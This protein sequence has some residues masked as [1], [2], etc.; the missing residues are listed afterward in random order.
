MKIR[1]ILKVAA[2]ALFAVI[3]LGLLLPVGGPRKPRSK[4]VLARMEMA[5]LKGALENYAS[6]YGMYPTGA[7]AIV[8][9]TLLGDNPRRIAFLNINPRS[10][11]S[12]GEYVDPWGTPYKIEIGGETN[13]FVR[14]AGPNR[15]FG[16]KDDPTW[17]DEMSSSESRTINQGT[18]K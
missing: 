10:I 4:I 5:V 9:K 7:P 11:N 8:L 6:T 17:D 16:D 3:A 12:N 13:V 2:V 1:V 15:K 18:G 14:S